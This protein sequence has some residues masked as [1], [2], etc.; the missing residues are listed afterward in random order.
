MHKIRVI[1]YG[2]GATGSMAVRAMVEHPQLQLVGCLVHN[3]EKVGRDVGELVGVGKIGVIATNNFDEILAMNADAVSFMGLWPDLDMICPLLESGKHVV[4]TCGLIYPKFL[5]EEVVARLERSCKIGNTCIFGGGVSPGYT[6][7]I[8][9]L[10]LTNLAR[11]VNSIL[12]EEL[13][14]FSD[15][16]ESGELLREMVG[17]GRT[18]EDVKNNK[19]PHFDEMMPNFFHQTVALLADAIKLPIDEYRSDVQYFVTSKGGYIPNVEVS[20]GTVGGVVS[21]FSG[22]VAGQPKI[23]VKLYWCGAEDLLTEMIPSGDLNSA[24]EWRV[25]VEGDPSMRLTFEQANSFLNPAADKGTPSAQH[26]FLVTA[27]NVLNAIPYLCEETAPGIKHYANLPLMG[28]R[29]SI[30]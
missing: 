9:P 1:Q 18:L 15:V 25:T 27:M 22:M 3:P 14:E 26:S 23:T 4:L 5:G 28:G 19:H 2:T 30:R 8:A 13:V 21:T 24:T 6:E 11:R 7:C 16:N 10:S 29:Y 12:V 17:F 20:P